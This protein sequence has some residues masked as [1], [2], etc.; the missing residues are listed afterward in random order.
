MYIIPFGI[1]LHAQRGSTFMWMVSMF[2][3]FGIVAGRIRLPS[4]LRILMF[5][6]MCSWRLEWI[7]GS[8]R[9]RIGVWE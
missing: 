1:D 9:A 5:S 6:L 4:M 2:I 8:C 7:D 3:R